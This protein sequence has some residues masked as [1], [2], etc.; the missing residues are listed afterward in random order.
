M[1]AFS[2]S[3]FYAAARFCFALRMENNVRSSGSVHV[4]V[5]IFKGLISR[6]KNEYVECERGFHFQ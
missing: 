6:N 5:C 4:I 1:C 2:T 3:M